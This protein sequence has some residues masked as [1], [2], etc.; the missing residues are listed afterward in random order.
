MVF[1]FGQSSHKMEC[2]QH[3]L[4][5]HGIIEQVPL[6]RLQSFFFFEPQFNLVCWKEGGSVDVVA[7]V[8]W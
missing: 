6:V 8:E 7:V 1:R 4:E 3:H 2:I 5:S